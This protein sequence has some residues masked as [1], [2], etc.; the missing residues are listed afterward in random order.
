MFVQFQLSPNSIF[1]FPPDDHILV[2]ECSDSFAPEV[3]DKVYVDYPKGGTF[4]SEVGTMDMYIVALGWML[5][6]RS[7]MG[8]E[9]GDRVLVR[10]VTLAS[11]MPAAPNTRRVHSAK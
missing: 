2:E 9:V 6:F 4:P 8:G 3:G 1:R 5:V 10:R 7:S 11:E